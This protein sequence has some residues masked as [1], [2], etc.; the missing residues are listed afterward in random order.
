MTGVHVPGRSATIRFVRERFV[1]DRG[2]LAVEHEDED[3][4]SWFI[5]FGVT[6]SDADEWRMTG[7]RAEPPYQWTC[8]STARLRGT[9]EG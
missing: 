1:D 3:D 5:V 2:L 6:R 9:P 8:V 4:R 7:D